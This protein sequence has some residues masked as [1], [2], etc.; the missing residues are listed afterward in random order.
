MNHLFM[1]NCFLDMNFSIAG[2][3]RYHAPLK[4]KL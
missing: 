1:V 3:G 4:V 2:T